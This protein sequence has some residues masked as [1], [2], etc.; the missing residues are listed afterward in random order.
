[1]GDVVNSDSFG[2]IWTQVFGASIGGQGFSIPRSPFDF[3]SHLLIPSSPYRF[4]FNSAL[5][6]PHSAF[7]FFPYLPI[8]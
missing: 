7:H 6:V 1:M 3:F 8:S 4:F 2:F 5:R